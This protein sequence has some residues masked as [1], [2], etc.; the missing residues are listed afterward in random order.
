MR[1]NY[2]K[3]EGTIV[4]GVDEDDLPRARCVREK[5]FY[6][7]IRKN[8]MYESSYHYGFDQRP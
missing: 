1:N 7:C 3:I 6:L 5:F 8:L 4:I 2:L